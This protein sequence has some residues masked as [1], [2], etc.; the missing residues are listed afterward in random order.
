MFGWLKLLNPK[1][2]AK[3]VDV[4]GYHFSW[5]SHVSVIVL[6]LSGSLAVGALFQLN[7][8]FL[9][10]ILA[11]A[12]LMLPVLILD[13]YRKMYEQKRFA[14]AATYM[15]QMLYAFQKNGKIISALKETREI[16]E[17]GQMRRTIGEAVAYLERGKAEADG[18]LFAEAL[19]M[20]EKVYECP[21]MRVIHELL[22]NE[23]EHGGEME[24]S[25]LILLDDLELWKRRGY[26]LQAE[27][28]KSHTDNSIS[29]LVAVGLCAAALYVLDAMKNMFAVKSDLMIFKMGVIQVSSLL[30]LLFLLGVFF[31]SARSLTCNWL[32]IEALHSSEYIR[33]SYHMLIN[34]D[35][36][37]ER[38]KSLMWAVPVITGCMLAL[39]YRKLWLAGILFI[40]SFFLLMQ[41]KIGFRLAKRDVTQEIYLAL[42]GWL[43]EL[44]LLLQNNNVQVSI[45]K[46]KAGASA[47][48]EEE[49]DALQKRMD[50]APDSLRSYT[51]FCSQFDVPEAQSCMKMLHAVSE[52]GTGNVRAQMNNLIVRVNEMQDMAEE[53]RAEQAAFQMKMIFSYPVIAAT[54]KLLADLTIG[55]AFMFQMLG[56]I[57]G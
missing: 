16:F 25:V 49:I 23:E 1:N 53:I 9:A 15:E 42:P 3:E 13:M 21:K 55:I 7:T 18:G 48:L 39:V 41:H 46:S 57:G 56:S 2:L 40:L 50:A 43:M 26:R 36:K 44:A 45:A 27:K 11:A 33:K 4:Y 35:K 37:K 32:Q 14:D 10:V 6:A 24:Q 31:K 51:D 52:M 30:F 17:D 47:V 5:K 19:G 12:I 8:P 34:Y 28:K 29:I 38:R 54:V 20:I 22:L